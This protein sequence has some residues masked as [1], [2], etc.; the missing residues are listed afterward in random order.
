MSR[1]TEDAVE[2]KPGRRCFSR[3]EA[4]AY[5]GIGTTLLSRIGPPPI[6]LGRRVLYDKLDLDRW[7]DDHKPRGRVI[8][9]DLWP[10]NEDCTD[11]K[12]HRTGGSMRS[13]R[14]DAEYAKALGL[15]S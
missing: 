13:S 15:K 7:L 11:A 12:T 8:E 3:S 6:R 5:L 4:A 14:T 1:S 10:E 2:E 9:E